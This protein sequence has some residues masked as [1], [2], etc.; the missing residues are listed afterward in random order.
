MLL[1]MN[2]FTFL[3]FP[4]PTRIFIKQL[5]FAKR[6]NKSKKHLSLNIQ[7]HLV[8]GYDEYRTL[9]TIIGGGGGRNSAVPILFP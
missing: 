9:D 5:K 8:D 4:F 7:F 3:W 6:T 2:C 1:P